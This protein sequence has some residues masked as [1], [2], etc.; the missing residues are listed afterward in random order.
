MYFKIIDEKLRPIDAIVA[1]SYE[2]A[3]K[4]AEELSPDFYFV[5]EC[6]HNYYHSFKRHLKKQTQVKNDW[7]K[8]Q[9]ITLLLMITVIFII[10]RSS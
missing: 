8:F 3:Y 5:E 2:D 7:H 10:I 9:I 6:S 1:N 4:I